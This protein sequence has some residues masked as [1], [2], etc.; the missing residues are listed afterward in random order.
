[1]VYKKIETI[2]EIYGLVVIYSILR[3]VAGL[4][5]DALTA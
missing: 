3:A 4:I 1:M 5:Y 2:N